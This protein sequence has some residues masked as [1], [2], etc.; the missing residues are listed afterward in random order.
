[1]EPEVLSS[2]KFP[3]FSRLTKI[4]D[5]PMSSINNTSPIEKFERPVQKEYFNLLL[6]I[7]DKLAV[8]QPMRYR[9]YP[10][11]VKIPLLSYVCELTSTIVYAPL[12]RILFE[13]EEWNPKRICTY[14]GEL[15]ISDNRQGENFPVDKRIE[16]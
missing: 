2:E 5:N 7:E 16:S 4:F 12:P 9:N 15:E 13:G 1:L 8:I 11:E 10:T 6:D 14:L 3:A